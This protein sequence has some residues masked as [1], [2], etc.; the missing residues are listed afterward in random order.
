MIAGLVGLILR[1][2]PIAVAL[3]GVLA[4]FGFNYWFE[5]TDWKSAA[6][7]AGALVACAYIAQSDSPMSRLGIAAV[8]VVA[9]YLKGGIDREEMIV[10]EY[11]KRIAE[12]QAAYKKVAEKETGRQER[13]NDDALKEVDKWKEKYD[14]DTKALQVENDKL[15]AA[16]SKDP[17]AKRPGLDLSAVDR[18]NQ[19]RLRGAKQQRQG[20]SASASVCRCQACPKGPAQVGD[21]SVPSSQG[22]SSKGLGAAGDRG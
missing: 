12:L 19:R 5:V 9:G 17:D 22:T 1:F 21:F 11:E 4:G 3:A 8:L 7:F 20:R 14:A 15:R 10:P 2:W 16:A 18:L 13:A 6:V